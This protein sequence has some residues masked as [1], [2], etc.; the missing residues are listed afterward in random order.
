MDER[1]RQIAFEVVLLGLL[2]FPGMLSLVFGIIGFIEEDEHNQALAFNCFI[3]FTVIMGFSC[4][5]PRGRV[6]W[7]VFRGHAKAVCEATWIL[8]AVLLLLTVFVML[9][10]PHPQMARNA[11]NQ[12]NNMTG[13]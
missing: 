3:F 12:W 5:A 7:N 2:L 1:D 10:K 8:W 13:P 9:A 4:C 11:I 6:M